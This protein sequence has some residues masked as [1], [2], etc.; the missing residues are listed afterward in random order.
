ADLAA[1]LEEVSPK[2]SH[3][4][5][6]YAMDIIRPFSAGMGLRISRL[7]DTYVEMVIPVRT[8]NL[9]E[10]QT[11]HEGALVT[12]ATEAAKML[13]MRHAPLGEFSIEVHKM[14]A[15]FLKS[16]AE[17]CRVRMEL[18]ETTRE[19]VLSELRERR[20]VTTE[21]EIRVFDD[22][23]QAIAELRLQLSLQHTPAL[24]VQ[25]EKE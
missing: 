8:R 11:L 14:E 21:A 5:L 15:S 22:K 12:A 17:E 1:I 2:A 19:M 6:S 23:D 25:S 10:R 3:A 13:W 20:E 9:N 7:G 16:C 18:S 4:A 24:N